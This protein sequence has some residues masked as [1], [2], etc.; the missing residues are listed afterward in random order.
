MVD[1]RTTSATRGTDDATD[2]AARAATRGARPLAR[3]E[4][5]VVA[6]GAVAARVRVRR[7]LEMI[8]WDTFAR[9]WIFEGTRRR[10]RRRRRQIEKDL[11]PLGG[12]STVSGFIDP[13][14]EIGCR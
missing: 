13:I 6:R 14:R 5:W 8:S 1:A 12:V 7:R 11:P 2:D 4:R 10:T 3:D 9:S